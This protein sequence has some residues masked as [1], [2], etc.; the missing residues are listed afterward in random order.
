MNLPLPIG[1]VVEP[2]APIQCAGLPRANTVTA[3]YPVRD[4]TLALR[5]AVWDMAAVVPLDAASAC[6]SRRGSAGEA[7]YATRADWLGVSYRVE[8]V[9]IRLGPR[10][11]VQLEVIS[12][13][14]KGT[15]ARELLAAW[16]KKTAVP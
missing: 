8:G 11:L 10:R 7:S 16:L 15:S 12:P 5:A 4:V 2:G 13:D 6:S 9:F 1:W 3:A 14:Q